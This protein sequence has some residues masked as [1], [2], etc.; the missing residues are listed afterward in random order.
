[1]HQK[2]GESTAAR[3]SELL[4][5]IAKIGAGDLSARMPVSSTGDRLD[6]I[7]D[8]INQMATELMASQ[9]QLE[10]RMKSRTAML[11]DA[12][13]KMELM[14]L[15]DPLTKLRNRAALET[16]LESS[17]AEAAGSGA[18]ALLLLDLDSFK[19]IN[20][21]LG[22]SA[23]DTVLKVVAERLR[24][25]VRKEDTVA[26]LG[27][28]EFAIVLQSTPADRARDVATRIVSSL[29]Q[30]VNLEDRVVAVGASV[31][32]A[33]S[34][35]N[36][37]AVD[38]ILYA[39][40]AMY[41]AKNAA[42]AN[43]VLFSRQLLNA[44]Q[45]HSA[46]SAELHNAIENNEMVLHYQPIV[47]L[48]T[49]TMVGVEALTRWQ[50]PRRGLVMPDEFIGVAD[51]IGAMASLT[52]WVLHESL[53]QL[54]RWQ[55]TLDLDPQFTMRI[56]ISAPQLQH[57]DLLADVQRILLDERIDPA[58]LVLELTEHSMVTGNEW[59]LYSFRGL[60]NLGVGLSIDDFGTGYSSIS[61]LRTLPADGVK[62]DKSLI[63][64][65]AES[66]AQ[67]PFISAILELVKSCN[68]TTTFEGVETLGQAALLAELGCE[69]G[70]GF[71]FGKPV[72]AAEI[73]TPWL[74]RFRSIPWKAEPLSPA[75]G[76]LDQRES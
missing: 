10:A 72:P 16:V 45:M 49:G 29:K 65:P 28:D 50:H 59:D 57:P 12:F 62:L 53:A 18:P 68:L 40:T 71:Y 4:A 6:T 60:R 69:T 25:A 5:G 22:H 48:R 67:R 36:D 54:R 7:I 3:L 37:S 58:A 24:A 41:A 26:R 27:G 13:R 11:M 31:G 55:E 19:S 70:Q 14:A 1:M 51:E 38:L 63:G 56:N 43:V 8:A 61:Y 73:D 44:R 52:T 66:A 75:P 32:I 35:P 20:D 15:T 39:D 47:D 17:L 2:P 42:N 46:I 9:A 30:P 74:H 33:I 64:N 76:A 21:T 23:G 34:E